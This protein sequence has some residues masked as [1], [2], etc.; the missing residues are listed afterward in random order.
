MRKSHTLDSTEELPASHRDLPLPPWA[1]YDRG[2]LRLPARL[3]RER[4]G[5]YRWTSEILSHIRPPFSH[6]ILTSC[7]VLEALRRVLNLWVELRIAIASIGGLVVG[8]TLHLVNH[9]LAVKWIL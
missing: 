3:P 2:T 8:E 4:Y 7:L 1:D 6:G 9:L 5:N